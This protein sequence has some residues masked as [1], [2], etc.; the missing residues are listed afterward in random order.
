MS[1]INRGLLCTLL[2]ALPVGSAFAQPAE[3]PVRSLMAGAQGDY[4][5]G[6]YADAEQKAEKAWATR[7]TVDIAVALGEIEL[8]L[9]KYHEAAQHFF[10]A[11]KTVNVTES[12]DIK[13]RIDDLLE[14]AKKGAGAIVINASVPGCAFTTSATPEPRTVTAEP[15]FLPPGKLTIEVV[16][17]GYKKE[18][19]T[20]T[21]IAGDQTVVTVKLVEE[22]KKDDT[23]PGAAPIWPTILLA[24][25][26]GA[27]LVTGIGLTVGSRVQYAD[28]EDIATACA[29]FTRACEA[30]SQAAFD[31]SAL[32]QN[33]GFGMFGLAAASALGLGLYL[34]LA[35]AD[36][37]SPT[38]I[39][40][41]PQLGANA[42]GILIQGAF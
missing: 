14:Q 12:P 18:S 38:A 42:G 30:E 17:E 39:R 20:V 22:Q 27:A 6:R 28:A 2:V 9:A 35:S 21:V 23:E 34:G 32:L 41:S 11:Q 40:F 33:V 24:S 4:E 13:K 36:A 15:V 5:A 16:K 10:Y 37:A 31:D 19:L 29:P 3:D 8:K 7:Q 25:V 1:T 26:G